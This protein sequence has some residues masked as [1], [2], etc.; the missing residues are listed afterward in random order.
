MF[1]SYV[2]FGFANDGIVQLIQCY[3]LVYDA[4]SCINQ[5]WAGHP[6]TTGIPSG[7]SHGYVIYPRGAQKSFLHGYPI[8]VGPLE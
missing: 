4:S 3:F 1:H 2:P 8:P 6:C 5:C 7:V